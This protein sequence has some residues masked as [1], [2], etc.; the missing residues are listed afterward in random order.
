MKVAEVA[1]LMQIAAVAIPVNS[2]IGKT[3]EVANHV[4]VI[5]SGTT[6]LAT[7]AKVD[8]KFAKYVVILLGATSWLLRER[9]RE[10]EN[11]CRECVYFI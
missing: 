2:D 11:T 4:K 5:N 9:E 8:S 6:I 10:R 3:A 1:K 7:N